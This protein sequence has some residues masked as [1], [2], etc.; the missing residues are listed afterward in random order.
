LSGN[1]Y[2]NKKTLQ[3]KKTPNWGG[4]NVLVYLA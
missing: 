3:K 1:W 4:D 2:G